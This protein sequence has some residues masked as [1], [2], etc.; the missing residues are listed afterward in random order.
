MCNFEASMTTTDN[1]F[2]QF[3]GEKVWNFDSEIVRKPYKQS[4]WCYLG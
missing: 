3:L 1:S 2:G 4:T